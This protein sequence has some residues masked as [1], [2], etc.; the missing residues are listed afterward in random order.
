LKS[1][2]F[3]EAL[4]NLVSIGSHLLTSDIFD[5]LLTL[6]AGAGGEMQLADAI[7]SWQDMGS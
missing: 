5:T 7:I 1:L 4:S 3:K 6:S 2:N